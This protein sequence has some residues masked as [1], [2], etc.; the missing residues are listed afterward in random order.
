[1][2]LP[3]CED[4]GNLGPRTSLLPDPL[5]DFQVPALS[6]IS[7]GTATPGTVV[8]PRPFQDLMMDEKNVS[9]FLGSLPWMRRKIKFP[10]R[11]PIGRPSMLFSGYTPISGEYRSCVRTSSLPPLAAL[12]HVSSPHGQPMS[13]A[14]F[15]ISRCPPAAAK[16]HVA[17]FQGQ[18]P[19]LAHFRISRCPAAAA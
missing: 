7:T 8:P 12:A 2:A 4:T 9:Y 15:R 11:N 16:A 5:Q 3:C 18:P 19:S 14:H 10:R 17:S 1:M 6:S 13:L